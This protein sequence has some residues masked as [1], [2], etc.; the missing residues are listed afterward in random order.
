MDCVD[1]GR[2]LWARLVSDQIVA[3]VPRRRRSADEAAAYLGTLLGKSDTLEEAARAVLDF[4]MR[5][6]VVEEVY[7]D[8][9]SIAAA[10][11]AIEEECAG[12]LPWSA[13]EATTASNPRLEAA[14]RERPDEIEPYLVYADWLQAQGDPR[15]E[16]IV[17]HER[18]TRDPEDLR[19]KAALHSLTR[20]HEALFL[21][22]LADY[23]LTCEREEEHRGPAFTWHLGFISSARFA[24]GGP[25]HDF[26]HVDL[27]EIVGYLGRHP[28]GRF[29]REL[30]LGENLR[31]WETDYQSIVDAMAELQW[32]SLRS[33]VLGDV[34]SAPHDVRIGDLSRLW[35]ALPELRDLSLSGQELAVG[36]PV[37]PKLLSLTLVVEE[38]DA[39]AVRAL[40]DGSPLLERLTIAGERSACASADLEVAGL[41]PLAR[42]ERL[43]HLALRIS[44]AGAGLADSVAAFLVDEKILDR[45][46]TLELSR[47]L[48]DRGLASLTRSPALRRLQRLDLSDNTLS[49]DA[50]DRLRAA[51]PALVLT[52]S[53]QR[54]E[55]DTDADDV[56][57]DDEE[58]DEDDR[59]DDV[60]E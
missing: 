9:E 59:Y 54:P 28:S 5:E 11:G 45:L 4:L 15:G 12:V 36:S 40:L 51:C 17:L 3:L 37:L 42:R 23:T 6:P 26:A 19:L 7:G 33:L 58:E 25:S 56:D 1:L 53:G 49:Q 20:R 38:L 41:Q 8:E 47:D 39:N 50:L 24:Y 31:R 30:T 60:E 29:L 18:L 2:L 48:T 52:T 34:E 46:E 27:A 14:I 43:R 55:E 22:R 21:G 44:G 13:A 16:L 35:P 32:P 57:D 10:L